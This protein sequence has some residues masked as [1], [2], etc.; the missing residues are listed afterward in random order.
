MPNQNSDSQRK[1][2]FF[3]ALGKFFSE[4]TQMPGDELYKS[5]HNVR[6]NEV[7]MDNIPFSPS[8]ASAS[9]AAIS[10]P[11]IL[12]KIGT[13]GN[14]SF[15]YP[16][17]ST[18]Y[19]TWFLDEGDPTWGSA[20]FNPSTQWVKSLISPTD[21][22]N[23]V[24]APSNGFIFQMFSQDGVTPIVYAS[25][26]YDVDYFSGLIRFDI[27]K[28]PKDI[29][30]GFTFLPTALENASNKLTYIR[31]SSTC[32]PRAIAYQYIGQRLSNYTFSGVGATG[33]TGATGGGGSVYTAGVGLTLSG[34]TFSIA[35]ASS[36]VIGGVIVGSG[37]TVS[38]T[39]VLSVSGGGSVYTA[40]V[41]LTLSGNTFSMVSTNTK[42]IYVSVN[43]SDSN[44]GLIEGSPFSNL[45][46]ARD[47]ASS[48]DMII[49][50]PG[51]FTFDN[52]D[53]NGN[54]WNSRLDD[55]NLWKNG[56]NYYFSPGCKIIFY[57]QS[58]TGG[59]MNLFRPRGIINETC[60]V[61]GYLEIEAYSYGPDTS[62]G[63]T[64]FFYG[65]TVDAVDVGYTCFLQVKSLY[66]E[67][68]EM[69]YISRGT[70]ISGTAKVTIEADSAI[71]KFVTGQGGGYSCLRINAKV[72]GLLEFHSNIRYMSSNFG[73]A[74]Q[75]RGDLSSTLIYIR[76]EV[77][78][79]TDMVVFHV[80][81]QPATDATF[82]SDKGVI[83]L[84]FKKIYFKGPASNTGSVI[85]TH[86]SF[87]VSVEFLINLKGDCIEYE[88]T[89]NAKTLFNVYNHAGSTAKKVI[90]YV[91]NIYTITAS[92]ETTQ[93]LY[94]QGR[95]I[96]YSM[97]PNTIVNIKGDI[98]YNG[99]VMTWRETFK[100]G[101]GGTINYSGNIRGNFGCPITKC[102]TGV[103][104]ISN[105][106]IISEIDSNVSSILSNG[107]CY[108][109]SNGGLTGNFAT[110]KVIINNSYIKL[111]N[112]SGYIGNGGYLDAIITNSI[113][114]NSGA[115]SG[116]GIINQV[117]YYADAA[118][119][120]A[121]SDSTPSGK[122]QMV[123]STILVG[124]SS[125]SFYYTD[126][127]VIASNS[128]TNA[129]WTVSTGLKG[130]LDLLSDLS[131]S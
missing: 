87:P 4:D 40:G 38:N 69:I 82:I 80:M 51:T 21:V 129:S 84:D 115:T 74:C 45:K 5:A 27:L 42:R 96:V 61:F 63:S 7:W 10:N 123:N 122:I 125:N 41:G 75:F 79:C 102:N 29:G 89:G 44:T 12:K 14:A 97:G 103:I 16:L 106:T 126:T 85:D 101:D 20:G 98:N 65:I 110:G 26:G 107:F 23:S 104:N 24:G 86:N 118:T 73:S 55:I 64:Y 99:S 111:K 120:G 94:S 37:L 113:I 76:G 95:R 112:S 93:S 60:N 70:T 77:I 46:T 121:P 58:V 18:N 56:V 34:S 32:G 116:S 78:I 108:I 35:T 9:A 39:G 62:N 114:I 54:Y 15:L 105:S 131:N 72:G 100:T 36:E 71:K 53:S 8:S 117:P 90:N 67:C 47:F 59:Q 109:N 128:T 57:N 83:N 6:S 127:T 50:L 17:S 49:V 28:T 1:A 30:L 13:S 31:N 130:S 25:A 43:G 48:G 3:H 81:P 88:A 66:S 33:A 2:G 68:M 19:Q 119:V 22:T 124:T 92:G 91:G 11:T 52:R